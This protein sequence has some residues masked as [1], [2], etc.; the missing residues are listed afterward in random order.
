MLS[1]KYIMSVVPETLADYFALHDTE[2]KLVPKDHFV[3]LL[4]DAIEEYA[5]TATSLFYMR[6]DEG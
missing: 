5:S 6:T 4:K 1:I 2:R 3:K